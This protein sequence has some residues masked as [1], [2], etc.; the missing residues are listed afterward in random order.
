[1]VVSHARHR[2]S[3][4]FIALEASQD[5]LKMEGKAE[6]NDSVE[7]DPDKEVEEVENDEDDHNYEITD[8]SM[9]TPWERFIQDIEDVLKKWGLADGRMGHGWDGEYPATREHTLLNSSKTKGVQHRCVNLDYAGLKL[10][11]RHVVWLPEG[12]GWKTGS[13]CGVETIWNKRSSAA[14]SSNYIHELGGCHGI[15]N[16]LILVP[17][18]TQKVKGGGVGRRGKERRERRPCGWLTL[19]RRLCFSAR[20]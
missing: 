16:Y 18:T 8:F 15:A 4:G 3:L 12:Q 9:V 19:T 20:H 1:M 13:V 17:D 6:G 2:I 10:I 11:L 7:E 5:P 14:T